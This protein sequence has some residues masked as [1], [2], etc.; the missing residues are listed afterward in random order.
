MKTENS[1]QLIGYL[2]HEPTLKKAYNG[3]LYTRLRVATDYFRRTSDGT[4]IKKTTWHDVMVWDQLAE[5][6]PDNFSKGSHILIRGYSLNRT[7]K[8]KEGIYKK[9]TEVK[10][11]HL[12]NLDR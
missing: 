6:V 4:V 12:L 10:A 11:N 3:S 2:G 1:I 8:N 7:F 9:I 5:K